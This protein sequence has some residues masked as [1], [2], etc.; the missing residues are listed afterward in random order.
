MAN[1]FV[2]NTA[3]FNPFTYQEV[4]API[5]EATKQQYALEE[6]IS[7]IDDGTLASYLAGESQDSPYVKGYNDLTDR[8]R[9]LSQQLAANGISPNLMRDALRLKG[10]FKKFSTPVEAAGKRKASDI[11][12]YNKM[13]ASDPTLIGDNPNERSLQWYI[14][15]PTYSPQY[16]SGRAFQSYGAT[17]GAQLA[18]QFS[19]TYK[20]VQGGKF[21]EV[22]TKRTATMDEI[23]NNPEYKTA[24]DNIMISQGFDPSN[25]DSLTARVRNEIESGMYMGMQDAG[26]TRIS[27]P[28]WG[29]TT[30]GTTGGGTK[31]KIILNKVEG[32][33]GET[34]DIIQ[35]GNTKIKV[36]TK[37]KQ[38]SWLTK[39]DEKYWNIRE[40]KPTSSNT[41][42][43]GINYGYNINNNPYSSRREANS[44]NPNAFTHQND[45]EEVLTNLGYDYFNVQDEDSYEEAVDNYFKI[46]END[47]LSDRN[48]RLLANK[49]GI[50]ISGEELTPQDKAAI[51]KE[52]NDR[53]VEINVVNTER[54]RNGK[55][56]K[57]DMHWFTR[58]TTD[59]SN[60]GYNQSRLLYEEGQNEIF[61]PNKV[62]TIGPSYEQ[63]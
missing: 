42:Q 15:N 35:R 32:K 25:N 8:T 10:D 5:V 48:Y 41:R 27:N 28:G 12:T 49:F 39:D 14:D 31:D 38:E 36:N 54:D 7:S 6:A 58:T 33:D 29:R 40:Q 50:R 47:K 16:T 23:K 34:Y 2:T 9:A 53:N 4:L 17:L 3:R 51:L 21:Y 13:Y 62:V 11:A 1:Y 46:P 26:I 44:T 45:F 52:A 37:T 43:K 20:P 22:Q 19:P 59:Q 57:Q 63:E 55:I 24:V 61:D 60:Q 56:K 30:S 18:S